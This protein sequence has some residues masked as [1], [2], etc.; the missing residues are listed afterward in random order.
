ML[1]SI[2]KIMEEPMKAANRLNEQKDELKNMTIDPTFFPE[3]DVKKELLYTILE[4]LRKIED[5]I[6]KQTELLREA[7]L[8]Q[9][10]PGK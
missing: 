3:V 2:S 5:A 6:E 10:R 7:V 8:P 1:Q 4:E 9:K